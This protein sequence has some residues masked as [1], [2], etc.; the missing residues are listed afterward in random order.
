MGASPLMRST[1]HIR[2][3]A[4]IGVAV[5][6]GCGGGSA[7][8]KAGGDDRGPARVLTLA[9]PLGGPQ[10]LQ[11]FADEVARR[12]DGALEIRFRNQ[13][14]EG[15]LEYERDL[16][17]DVAAGK[18]DLGWVGS[19]AWD[20]VGVRSFDPLTAPFVISSYDVEHKVL[21]S[22]VVDQMLKAVEPLGLVGLGILPGPL[23]YLL[24]A[25]RPLRAP[26]DFA[27]LRVGYQ[28]GGPAREALQALGAEPVALASS[29]EFEGID[30]IEQQVA[31]INANAY[32][33]D[34]KYLTSNV[35]LWPRPLVVFA[36]KR[37]MAKLSDD[38]R[39]LL[40]DAM[41]AA[42]TPALKI[43]RAEQRT[44]LAQLCERRLD[45]AVASDADL[46]AL[47]AAVAPVL[48]RLRSDEQTRGAM[49][50][51]ERMRDSGSD[52]P[53]LECQG[54]RGA[55]AT[56]LPDG[57]YT[58]RVTRED[59]RRGDIDHELESEIGKI[60]T[61]SAE[62]VIKGGSLVQSMVRSD[63]R[64]EVGVTGQYSVFRDRFSV[65]A[66]NGQEFSMRFTF[67]GKTLRFSDI[68]PRGS[69]MVVWVSKPWRYQR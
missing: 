56:A 31:S 37:A 14:R 39:A 1:T 16:I 40:R 65:S 9:N 15:E 7:V 64:R 28:R 43:T 19:R 41:R 52:E 42:I 55:S 35:V 54:P 23:R 44:A 21:E 33:R 13:W 45:V 59:V 38:H 63:G 61:S 48:D 29:A 10:E 58:T 26:R 51:I 53:G 6:A 67:D 68:K 25:D 8:D 60:A 47:R 66:T 4:L 11:A 3:A 17:R 27:G 20:T 46:A 34:A 12:S 49:A 5:L 18:A 57:T 24:A 32:D 36:G 50:A 2:A 69:Y 22:A 30:A 62:L